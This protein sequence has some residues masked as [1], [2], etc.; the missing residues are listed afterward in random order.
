MT[1]EGKV[2]DQ[3]KKVFKELGIWYYMPPGGAAFGRVGVPDFLLCVD[4]EFVAIETKATGGKT[5]KLQELEMQEIRESGGAAWVVTPDNI[6]D[7]VELL[8]EYSTGHIPL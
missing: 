4:G 1:P 6:R 7:T 2:K 8:E 5:T 3:L